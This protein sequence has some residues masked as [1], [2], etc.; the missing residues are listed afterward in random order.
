[1]PLL[2]RVPQK[3]G[4]GTRLSVATSERAP[5]SGRCGAGGAG[6]VAL[7]RRCLRS[8]RVAPGTPRLTAMRASMRCR[9]SK[10]SRA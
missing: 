5:S 6:A 7:T 10:A 8:G 9:P 1:M 4:V 2:T 3:G